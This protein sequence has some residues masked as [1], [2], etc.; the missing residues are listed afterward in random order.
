MGL[1]SG[2]LKTMSERGLK[3]LEFPLKTGM[4]LTADLSVLSAGAQERFWSPYLKV[5]PNS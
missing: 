1:S 2:F 3:R 4:S 5:L